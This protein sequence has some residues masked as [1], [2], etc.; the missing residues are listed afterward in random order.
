MRAYQPNMCKW[1]CIII[2]YLECFHSHILLHVAKVKVLCA[3]KA[4]DTEQNDKVS[5]KEF[6]RL[7]DVL[8]LR[9]ERVSTWSKLPLVQ[10]TILC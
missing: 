8:S 1:S 5:L 4:L 6:Y 10:I 2:Y 3:F 7:Y 9:W